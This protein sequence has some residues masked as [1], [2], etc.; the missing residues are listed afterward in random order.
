MFLRHYVNYQ[1]DDWMDWLATAEFSYNN[2][3]HMATRRIPVQIE[4]WKTPL[5]RRPYGSNG[6]TMS[7]RVHGTPAEE[8]GTS[9]TCNER[10]SEEYE[11]TIR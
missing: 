4:L 10:V 11:I 7:R 3:K 6:D 2:K 5:E 8:L 9:Y 1:Q